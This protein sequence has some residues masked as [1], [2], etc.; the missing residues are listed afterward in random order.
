MNKNNTKSTT[1]IHE[2]DLILL[3]RILNWSKPD[4]TKLVKVLKTVAG[5]ALAM[6]LIE[7]KHKG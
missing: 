2:E 1:E 4:D 5:T 6:K 3:K 7:D